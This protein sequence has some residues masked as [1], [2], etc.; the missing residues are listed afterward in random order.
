[1]PLVPAPI[2]PPRVSVKIPAVDEGAK[3]MDVQPVAS[4]I[5]AEVD[6]GTNGV[7]SASLTSVDEWTQQ[8]E[9]ES[10]DTDQLLDLA[11]VHLGQDQTAEAI[12]AEYIHAEVTGNVPGEEAP[13]DNQVWSMRAICSCV[14]ESRFY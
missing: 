2:P 14:A 5:E 6:R 4:T 11:S 7:R 1:M 13:V 10:D 12:P 9:N 8:V 3:Q